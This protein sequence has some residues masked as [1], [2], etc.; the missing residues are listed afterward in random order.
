MNTLTQG[1]IIKRINRKLAPKQEI[2]RKA[3]GARI[4]ATFGDFYIHDWQQNRIVAT[5]CN[6]AETARE[7]GLIHAMEEVA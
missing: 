6:P 7:L 4:A 3:R 5:H 1:A 2:F